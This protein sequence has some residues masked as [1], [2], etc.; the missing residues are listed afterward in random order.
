MHKDRGEK[1]S[2]SQPHKNKNQGQYVCFCLKL[3]ILGYKKKKNQRPKKNPLLHMF[4][5]A[6]RASECACGGERVRR[7]EILYL[8]IIQ[9]VVSC[10]V[11]FVLYYVSI[12]LPVDIHL[13]HA[14]YQKIAQNCVLQTLLICVSF[15]FVLFFLRIQRIS[16]LV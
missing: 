8:Y 5:S 10:L 13:H 7:K 4:E 2:I 6:N 14:N 12:C 3:S 1:K 16:C 9:Y 11:Y 15:L